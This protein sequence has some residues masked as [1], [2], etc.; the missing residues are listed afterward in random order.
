[1]VVLLTF[2][3]CTGDGVQGTDDD[4]IAFL[5]RKP[6]AALPLQKLCWRLRDA[7]M[8]RRVLSTLRRRLVFNSDVWSYGLLH[9]DVDAIREFVYGKPCAAFAVRTRMIILQ[10][11]QH[12][13]LLYSLPAVT[14]AT[15]ST[16]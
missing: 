1:V 14:V 10:D 3:L 13:T 8:Y 6:L 4:V 12:C 16:C 9:G 5:E 11:D 15:R 2:L 7:D